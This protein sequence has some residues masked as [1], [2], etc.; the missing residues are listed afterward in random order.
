MHGGVPKGAGYYHVNVSLF[1]DKSRAP[2]ADAQVQMQLE[3]PGLTTVTT[4]LEP[5]LIGAGSYGNYIKPEARTFYRITLSIARPQGTT[6][7]VEAKFEHKF[8]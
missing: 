3:Q 1:D 8:E 2:I 5:M 4:E 6:R 7:L